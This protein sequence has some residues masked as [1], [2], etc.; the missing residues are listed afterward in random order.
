MRKESFKKIIPPFLRYFLRKLRNLLFNPLKKMRLYGL[1]FGD[2]L[3]FKKT[4]EKENRFPVLWKNRCPRLFDKTE[5]TSFDPHYIYHTAWAARILAKTKPQKHVDISSVLY[6]PTIVS[7]FVPI[8]FYDY[9]PANIKLE[10]FSAGRADLLSLPFPDESI[11]SLSCMH[12]IEH[13]GLGRYGDPIDPAGDIKALKEIERVLVKNGNFLFVVPT[14]KSKICFNA[15]RIYSYGQIMQYFKGFTLQE[16][17][18]VPDN[19]RTVGIVKN[20][21]RE[22]ADKQECGCG[23]FWFVKKT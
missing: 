12:T 4:S 19:G 16:F 10:N 15:H 11:R 5:E 6:F 14:G 2:Y 7:A 18:L 20:A 23:L 3:A 1:F 21:T 13:L 22:Q 9:R 8:E 17:S